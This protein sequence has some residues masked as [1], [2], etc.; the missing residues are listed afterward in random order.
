MELQRSTGKR[1]RNTLWENNL[2][3]LLQMLHWK[4]V[5][6]PTPWPRYIPGLDFDPI[7]FPSEEWSRGKGLKSGSKC[8][9]ID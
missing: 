1:K 3:E 4:E 2:C 6:T 9:V 7:H 8:T 5:P